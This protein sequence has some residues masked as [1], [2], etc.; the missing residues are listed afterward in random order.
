MRI[1]RCTRRLM[2]EYMKRSRYFFSYR[3]GEDLDRGR[4]DDVLSSRYFEAAAGGA[5]LLG[6]RPDTPGYEARFGWPD[7]AINIPYEAAQAARDSRRPRRAA[8]APRSSAGA[9]RDQLPAPA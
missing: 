3:P 2:A 7:S 4:D 9:E 8:R 6:S 1:I 5:V